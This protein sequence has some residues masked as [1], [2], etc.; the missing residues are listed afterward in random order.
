MDG[1][2][3]RISS[4][5]R[6][7]GSASR[8]FARSESSRPSMAGIC[9]EA[10][11]LDPVRA[12]PAGQIL[13]HGFPDAGARVRVRDALGER[14]APP[15][16]RPAWQQRGRQSRRRSQVR[17]LV[18]VDGQA[19]GAGGFDPLDY[20]RGRAPHRRAQRLDVCH[21]PGDSR[22]PGHVDD[23]F[24]RGDHPDRVVGLVADVAGVDAV[25][26]AGD[27]AKFDQLGVLGV[28]AGRVEGAGRESPGADFHG[29][30]DEGAHPDELVVGG[31]PVVHRQ[32]LT[33]DGAVA[34]QLGSVDA[35]PVRFQGGALL[36]EVDRAAAVRIDHH[37][38][39]AHGEERLAV[40]E[41]RS[42]EAGTRMG[43]GVDEPG[44][45]VEAA[46]VQGRGSRRAGEVADRRDAAVQNCDVRLP[47]RG[48][49]A[50][51]HAPALQ[52]RVVG[53][54]GAGGEEEG[55][56]GG[57]CEAGGHPAGRREWGAFHGY[58]LEAR[59]IDQHWLTKSD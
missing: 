43:V 21:H 39:E 15:G 38:R 50:I 59:T 3:W 58:L 40:T 19:L 32:D 13:D 11:E 24:D 57:Q 7:M 33:P 30:A 20:G 44:C 47:G 12:A 25:E 26:L 27:P 53:G 16:L 14:L 45:D 29:G 48:T 6:S 55:G 51:H 23:L 2:P 35:E 31:G 17:V 34:D 28:A 54:G 4:S 18:G 41:F 9:G 49:G 42:R 56:R 8:S 36:D 52:D 46:H 22:L 5:A 10:P 37:G 1:P